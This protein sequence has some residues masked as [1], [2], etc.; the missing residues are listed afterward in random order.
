M[1]Y[2]IDSNLKAGIEMLAEGKSNKK[3]LQLINKSAQ[4][5]KTKGKSYFEIGRI[6]RE[7]VN[8]IEPNPEEARRYY[9]KAMEIFLHS[10]CDSMDHREMGDYYHYG[11]G[12]AEVDLNRALEYYDMAANEGDELAKQHV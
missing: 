4:S 12:F 1:S 5:G 3:A 7:G 2:T 8:G 9:D 11:L 6:L 10:P